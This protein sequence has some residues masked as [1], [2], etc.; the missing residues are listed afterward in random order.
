MIWQSLADVPL[1]WTTVLTVVAAVVILRAVINALI[2]HVRYRNVKTMSG[3]Y[4]FIGNVL[5]GIKWRNQMPTCL[6][7]EMRAQDWPQAMM[8]KVA[9]F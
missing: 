8:L 6:V 1:T 9:S 5:L 3:Y 2:D 4:P 7:N